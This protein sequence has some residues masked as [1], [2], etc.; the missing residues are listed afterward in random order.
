[1]KRF[2]LCIPILILAGC[3]DQTS[4]AFRTFME[5]GV[6]VAETTGGPRYTVPVFSFEHLFRIEQDDT[7]EETLLYGFNWYM[8]GDDGCFYTTD[9]GNQRIAVFDAAGRY[10]HSFGQGG[11]GPGEFL[12]PRLLYSENDTVAVWD[13]AM[14]NWRISYFRPNGEFLTSTA[15]RKAAMNTLGAWPGPA[16]S[17]IHSSLD[18][19]MYPSGPAP[20]RRVATISPDGDTLGV[21][22]VEITDRTIRHFNTQLNV[23]YYRRHGILKTVGSEPILRWYDLAGHPRLIIR[24]DGLEQEPVT[25]DERRA[26]LEAGQALLESTTDESRRRSYQTR[27]EY[28]IPDLKPYWANISVD[29]S[30]FMW[31]REPID[32]I[33]RSYAGKVCRIISPDGEYL[34]DVTLPMIEGLRQVTPSRGYLPALVENLET[35]AYNLEVYRIHPAVR[36]VVYP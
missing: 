6:S 15:V 7:R 2:L 27:L 22:E 14:G 24:I 34:G 21:V 35:G 10:S 36:G 19:N 13:M 33:R 5:N 23:E 18:Y 16:G 20:V 29:E 25:E 11:Q 12:S 30:G 28:P 31:A 8:V 26:I 32:L 17:V 4:H 1:M 9:I 3:S